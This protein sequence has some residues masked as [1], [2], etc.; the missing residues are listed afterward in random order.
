MS[1]VHIE[2][3]SA[4]FFKFVAECQVMVAVG[5]AS[6]L[7]QCNAARK[8]EPMEDAVQA[9]ERDSALNYFQPL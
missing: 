1:K 6:T 8:A 5:R 2:L 7:N 3:G 9:A 4:C